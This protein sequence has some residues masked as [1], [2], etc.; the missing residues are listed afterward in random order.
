MAPTQARL[1]A[2][3]VAALGL[4]GG[5]GQVIDGRAVRAASP[6][7][8]DQSLIAD[9]FERSNTAAGEGPQAQQ[10][11]LQETQHPDVSADGCS[12]GNVT[13]TID[14]TLS[15]LRMDEGWRPEQ[16]DRTPRGRIYIVAVTVTVKRDNA[17]IGTQIGSVHVVVLDGTAY[18]F[19]PCPA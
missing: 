12:L 19:A 4:L 1:V 16:A 17:Q 18:G 9:Y 11:F 15:T 10:R 2:V 7:D 8:A 5:C 14:P 13:L 6:A 3:L